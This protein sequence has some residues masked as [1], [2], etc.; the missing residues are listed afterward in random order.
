MPYTHPSGK[1]PKILTVFGT[2]PEVIKLAP[3]VKALQDSDLYSVVICNTGQHREMV[4]QALSVFSIEP[5]Y[6]LS[7]MREN[8]KLTVIRKLKNRS[9]CM[10]SAFLIFCCRD[11]KSMHANL[12]PS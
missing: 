9:V 1:K 12:S 8:Q 6:N 3:V 10:Q 5:D 11:E 7:V 4:D 2:R